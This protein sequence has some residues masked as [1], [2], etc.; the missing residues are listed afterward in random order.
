M[1]FAGISYKVK[2]GHEDRIARVFSPENFQ[3]VDSPVLRDTDGAELG[4]LTCTGLFIRDDTM[5]RVIQHDGGTTADIRRH[6]SVQE[7]VHAAER[8]IMPYLT[9]PRDTETPEGFAAHFD[10]SAMTVLGLQQRDN[11][12][13]AG[14]VALHYRVRPGS[15]AAV[16]A[17]YRRTEAVLRRP[18]AAESPVIATF[19]LVRDD[20]VVRVVQHDSHDD[21]D[22]LRFL[23]G[24]PL[25]VATDAWLAPY[26]SRA[27]T[28]P[29]LESHV[30]AHRMRCVSHLSAAVLN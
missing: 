21:Q 4:Y 9:E 8:E 29:D 19:L 3:R 26:L 23:G 13:A 10:R 17:A 15:G 5:V 2:P 20:D 16:A 22:V 14:L 27:R 24:Q 18:A 30:A 7:G 12:P 6:M 28:T 1:P 11:R 25:S